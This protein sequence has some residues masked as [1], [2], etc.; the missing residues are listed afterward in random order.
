[1]QA[2]RLVGHRDNAVPIIDVRIYTNVYAAL[3]STGN[4][5]TYVTPKVHR[6]HEN[7]KST[8]SGLYNNAG[9]LVAIHLHMT[10]GDR[11]VLHPCYIKENIAY[12]IVLG[13][14]FLLRYGFGLRMGKFEIN[15]F[16][17]TYTTAKEVLYWQN[18]IDAHDTSVNPP[19]KQLITVEVKD[20]TEPRRLNDARPLT[21]KERRQ[22]RLASKLES[23]KDDVLALHPSDTDDELEVEEFVSF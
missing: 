1:M 7:Q 14:D 3:I 19:H 6:E 23:P 15:N 16:S 13:S 22:K 10:I 8:S 20:R 11:L 12:D 4:E 9:K 2:L 5:N 21:P 18:I 17:P